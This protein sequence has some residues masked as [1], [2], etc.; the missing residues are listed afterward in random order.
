MLLI[1]P[2]IIFGIW[3]WLV[4]PI[5]V[6]EGPGRASAL[7]RS[8]ELTRGYRG[9]I[10][11]AILLHRVLFFI[12]VGIVVW[13]FGAR[14]L[15]VWYFLAFQDCLLAVLM[16]TSTVMGLLMYL[17]IAARGK[18]WCSACRHPLVRGSGEQ[19]P[20]CGL[21]PLPES[22]PAGGRRSS[23]VGRVLGYGAAAL[24]GVVL[25]I[26][27]IV[28]LAWGP[29]VR[30]MQQDDLAFYRERIQASP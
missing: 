23:R 26:V 1:V 21:L 14:G 17:G 29:L 3:F 28:A 5:V 22:Q 18:A 8:R 13:F 11:G 12:C 16:Q 15:S 7:C 4:T 19:C 20:K 2:G 24:G 25:M 10:L 9:R 30:S 27:A 6:I